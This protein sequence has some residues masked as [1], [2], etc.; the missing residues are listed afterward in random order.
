MAVT[1]PFR[2]I[3]LEQASVVE[4]P[5]LTAIVQQG[6]QVENAPSWLQ[7]Q[8]QQATD[9]V[10]RL[11]MP[12]KKDEDWRFI[13]L[14]ELVGQDWIRNGSVSIDQTNIPTVEEAATRLVFVNGVYQAE[15][16]SVA[17]T[18]GVYAG[19]ITGLS[20]NLPLQKYL[21]QGHGSQDVFTALNTASFE[22]AAVVWVAKNTVAQP[23]HL[24]FVSQAADRA[25]VS[26][27]RLVV[28][29]ETGA[30][31]SLVE[32]YWGSG[33]Q[34]Y[35][36][37]AVSEIFVEANA[38]VNHIRIQ[39]ESI[40]SF[41]M[42]KTAVAQA[43]DSRYKLKEINLGARVSRHNPEI[44][45]QGEQ[46][47][48]VL[49]ALTAI[50][51]KQEADT[52]SII[53]LSQ[54]HGTTEQL[55]KCIIGD[56]AH[57]IFNGKVYVPQAAQNTSAA[58]LNRNLLLAPNARVDTKPELQITADNVKCSHGATVSQLEAE[59][60]FYLRSRGLNESQSRRLLVDAFASEIVDKIELA[61]VQTRLKGAI[62]I[63]NRN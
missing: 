42:G 46:T 60:L 59:E 34:T 55:H 63:I 18:D 1:V 58:Q 21:A 3:D 53:A 54:P 5:F 25:S 23:I 27:P 39:Q 11:R 24:E 41:H 10:S 49:D 20:E 13:D 37:N 9:W 17:L 6:R 35:F 19:S 7:A 33:E 31:V 2:K 44:L 47:T 32:E 8:Q 26:H 61:S 52:H 28:V 40:N 62:A 15:L 22:D 48:T 29:A 57:A 43:K 50:A 38:E 12:T 51:N 45:Q 14:S 36:T 56:R 30:K 4:D 16:S